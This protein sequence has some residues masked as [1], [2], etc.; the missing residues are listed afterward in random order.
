MCVALKNGERHSTRRSLESTS[1][2]H[3]HF[4]HITK[5]RQPTTPTLTEE[6]VTWHSCYVTNGKVS[7]LKFFCFTI[8]HTLLNSLCNPPAPTHQL[9]HTGTTK[10][11]ITTTHPTMSKPCPKI[12]D[13]HPT[14]PYQRLFSNYVPPLPLLSSMARM[15][16]NQLLFERCH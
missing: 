10:T 3:Y 7:F 8:R 11:G 1:P 15:R 4:L 2:R 9:G 16:C 6:Q 13:S 14:P 12:A 5:R